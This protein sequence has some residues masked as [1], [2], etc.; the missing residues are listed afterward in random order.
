M[1]LI[2][3]VFG[4]IGGVIISLVVAAFLKRPSPAQPPAV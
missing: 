2:A 1:A 4:F 3:L